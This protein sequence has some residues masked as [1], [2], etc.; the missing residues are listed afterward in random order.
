METTKTPT[1]ASWKKVQI[2]S[3]RFPAVPS[4][5][6]AKLSPFRESVTLTLLRYSINSIQ[7]ERHFSR[8]AKRAKMYLPIR[9]VPHLLLPLLQVLLWIYPIIQILHL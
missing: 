6:S 8:I 3:L 2:P 9:Q 5:R 4:N 1:N 7:Y